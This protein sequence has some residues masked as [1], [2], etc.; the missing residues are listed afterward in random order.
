MKLSQLPSISERN[1][2]RLG[3][4]TGSGR[5][6]TGGRGTKGQTSRGKMP[7][8]F[9]GGQAQLI[10]R[11]PFLRGKG[12][13]DSMSIKAFPLLISKLEVFENGTTITKALLVKQGL[14]KDGSLKVKCLGGGTLSKKLTVAIPCS[15]SARSIIEKA[16][17]TVTNA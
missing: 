13:N 17:G 15:A 6:K 5:G 4:G 2:R 14:L 1:K 11:L 7:L 10:K 12:R 3:Q 16:G 8:A 9:E